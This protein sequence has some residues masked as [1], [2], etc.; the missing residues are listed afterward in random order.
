MFMNSQELE[1]CLI[2]Q[3]F[4]TMQLYKLGWS[5][6]QLASRK[7]N[8][9]VG[10]SIAGIEIKN[11]K[12]MSDTGNIYV[13]LAEKGQKGIFV[14][15]GINRQDNTIFWCIGDFKTVY[16]LVKKQLKYLC[17]NY[18]KFGFKTVKTETSHGVL[19]PTKFL[20]EHDIYVVKKLIF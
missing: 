10:E 16:I 5:V 6:N 7:Y 12:R 3:D 1:E 13:E 19:I 11:D 2:Y 20:D 14:Q 18:Q 9:E 8:I 17:D 4:I 15:S